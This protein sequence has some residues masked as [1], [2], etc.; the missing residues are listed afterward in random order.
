MSATTAAAPNVIPFEKPS[1]SVVS[2]DPE[3]ARRWLGR[4]DKNRRL[5]PGWS[6]PTPPTCPRG[7]GS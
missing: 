4:N 2:I 1:A 6:A 3:T 7:T 5:R